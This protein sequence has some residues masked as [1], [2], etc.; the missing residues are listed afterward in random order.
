MDPFLLGGLISGIGSLGSSLLN[1][2]VGYDQ[3]KG[4]MDYQYQL[5]QQAIDK[6]N[7]YNHPAEQ[8]KRLADAQLSPNLVYGSGVDGN[9]AS[10]ANPSAVNRTAKFDNPLQDMGQNLIAR[11]QF[12]L[13]Q[14][15][16]RNEAFESR[17]RRLNLEAK[18]LGVLSDNKL[19]SETLDTNIK[20]AG[21]KLANMV[22]QE[23][24]LTQQSNNLRIQ[25]NNL[26]EN[27]RLIAA[28]THLTVEQALTE[29]V[30]RRSIAAGIELTQKQVA[31]AASY[32]EFLE[33][34]TKLRGQAYNIQQTAYDAAKVFQEWKAKHPTATLTFEMVKEILGMGQ[35]LAGMAGQFIP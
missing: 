9:Q 5:Q 32:I 17:A 26:V 11:R 18:T 13:Q 22:A 29:E 23:S 14:I 10:P 27:T 25:A 28:R 19:K 3:S 24:V 30:K 2:T 33:A 12:E 4:L 6:A 34:G 21:Q 35:Q 15:A 1:N 31:Q 7:A 8:M 16:A 20:I